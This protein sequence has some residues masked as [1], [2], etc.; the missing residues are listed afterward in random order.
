MG[1]WLRRI[2][3]VG[4]ATVL[5]YWVA[6]LYLVGLVTWG[7]LCLLGSCTPA[8][9]PGSLPWFAAAALT[10]VAA[11]ALLTL[12]WS[13]RLRSRWVLTAGAV[14]AASGPA[15]MVVSG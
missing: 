12:G 3:A 8:D 5:G 4:V 7:G 13:G 9:P 10:A 11:V 1:V 14:V 2:A 15:I 6:T